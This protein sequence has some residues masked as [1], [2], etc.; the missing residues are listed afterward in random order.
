MPI[1]KVYDVSS[2]E[3]IKEIETEAE[4]KRQSNKK[5]EYTID[6]IMLVRTT[7][8]L[9]ENRIMKP[10]SETPNLVKECQNFLYTQL[11]AYET[12]DILKHLETYCPYYRTTLHTTENGLVSSHMYG[13]FDSRNF[14]ILEPLKEQINK[15]NIR[16]F[17]GQD[18]IIKGDM[19]LS[20]K[21][22]VIID[23][24]KFP[25][26][27]EKY[28]ELKDYNIC[29]YHGITHQDKKKYMD[30][31]TD[32]TD[33]IL[34]DESAVVAKILMD[35]G[36]TPEIIGTHYIIKSNTSDKIV[37]L[38]KKLALE[39]G[40]EKN[41][42]HQYTEEYIEDAKVRNEITNKCDRILLNFIIKYNNLTIPYENLFDNKGNII[43]DA[44]NNIKYVIGIDNLINT[45]E[46]F[47]NTLK[48]LQDDNLLKSPEEF[49]NEDDID[50]YNIYQ[51]Q[52]NKIR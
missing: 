8:Y 36:Y 47:N 3:K 39:K 9:P 27:F 51:Q 24:E 5:D 2:P 28:D 13:N 4:I 25:Q 29:L 45:V 22:I 33:I 44:A 37:E 26:L 19:I 48:K 1:L 23:Y 34:Q 52:T 50:I 32:S 15:S 20:E 6:D 12:T 30:E 16:N 40:V 10:Y 43:M 18:T 11:Y 35:L 46:I 49:K 7:N 31:N 42:K 14:I 38:N 41:T 17:A 21:S